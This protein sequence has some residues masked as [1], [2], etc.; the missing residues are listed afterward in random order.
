MIFAGIV[1]LGI[2][3]THKIAGPLHRIRGFARSIGEGRLDGDIKLR[4][5]DVIHPFAESLNKMTRSYNDR[6]ALLISE[7]EEL[8]SAIKELK[9]RTEKGENTE[10]TVKKILEIDGRIKNL[11]DT[12]KL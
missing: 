1:I 8:K 10:I 5:K 4:Q 6:V 9:S 7:I 3:Y 12:I 2:L 11:L